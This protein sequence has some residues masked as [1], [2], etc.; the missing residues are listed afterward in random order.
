MDTN[1]HGVKPVSEY[2]NFET[3]AVKY[4]DKTAF[5]D[6]KEKI[7]YRELAKRARIKALEAHWSCPY[8]VLKARQEADF[9]EQFLAVHYAHRVPIVVNDF[10]LQRLQEVLKHLKGKWQFVD[11]EKEPVMQEEPN[12]LLFLGLTSGTTGTPKVYCRNWSSWRSG[13][14]ICDTCFELQKCENIATPSPFATSLGLHTL[15]LSLY[16]GKTICLVKDQKCLVQNEKAVVFAVPSFLEQKSTLINWKNVVKLVLCGGSLQQHLLKK[17]CVQAPETDIFEIYGTSETSLI[18]WH[19]LNRGKAADCVGKPFPKVELIPS[20]N[21][22]ITVKSP[23]LFSGYLGSN[24]KKTVVTSDVGEVKDGQIFIYSRQ[25]EVID[26]GGNK[27]FPSEIEEQLTRF[28]SAAVAFGVPDKVYGER[29]V[30]LVVCKTAHAEFERK[31]GRCLERFKCP[32]EYIYVS[33]IP[34]EPNQKI[35][36]LRL[37]KR[38]ERGDFDDIR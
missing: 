25:S 29:V 3:I 1:K 35:S 32:Q 15:M 30:A 10:M 18:S 27:I 5:R 28:A 16:L 4:A 26:H 9:I 24:S 12:D 6:G 37:V 2:F 8:I 11:E 20:K 31:V 33:Q 17:L 13:F 34:V 19:K 21:S 36:R 14:D 22:L 23:Y 38:Y 7:T